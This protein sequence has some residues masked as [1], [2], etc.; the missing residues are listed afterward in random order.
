MREWMRRELPGSRDGMVLVD[1]DLAVRRYGDRYG[2][3]AEGDLLLLEK[4]EYVGQLTPGERRV[5]DWVDK[6]IKT[7]R[8]I[9]R[10]RGWNFLR[11]VYK[12][13]PHICEQ[14][15]Q[16]IE[17][18]DQ[19]YQRFLKATLYLGDNKI[20]HDDLRLLLEKK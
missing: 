19:A 14:C 1:L 16:P 8:M 5:Y 9:T 10:W 11:I 6:A 12:E 20:T 18:A 17:N 2:L 13:P 7:S 15:K 3:D 4:K